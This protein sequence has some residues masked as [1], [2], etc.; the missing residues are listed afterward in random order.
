M[1]SSGNP[2][3]PAADITQA[4]IGAFYSTYNELG[5]GFPEFVMRRALS[6]ALH[7]MGLAVREEAELPVWF[8][9]YQIARFRADMLVAET[10]L[11]EVKVRPEIEPFHVAQVLHYLRASDI[12]VGLLLNFGRE[13]R[14]KRIVFEN[15]RKSHTAP[16]N[17]DDSRTGSRWP[18]GT[19]SSAVDPDRR[20]TDEPG[21]STR[22]ARRP[23]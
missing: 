5:P 8:R 9:G 14:F 7:E 23:R 3:L 2:A 4:V 19:D 20:D 11:V 15:G 1:D 18:A 13:P 22:H 21:T 10:V 12:E 17:V 16:V 6:I